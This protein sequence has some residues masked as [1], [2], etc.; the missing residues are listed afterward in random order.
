M[1]QILRKI[2]MGSMGV[3]VICVTACTNIEDKYVKNKYMVLSTTQSVTSASV[4]KSLT[5]NNQ[6]YNLKYQTQYFSEYYLEDEEGYDWTKL[7]TIHYYPITSSLSKIKMGLDE[8]MKKQ[9]LPFHDSQLKYDELTWQMVYPPEI[10]SKKFNNIETDTG[11]G[12]E[13]ECGI[14]SVLYGEQHMPADDVKQQIKGYIRN[15][16]ANK[17]Q[18]SKNAKDIIEKNICKLK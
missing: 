13:T 7:I 3:S 6:E 14:V 4:P 12:M 2:L 9:D 8:R 5:Y 16:K 15:L 11:F 17:N 18:Y 10:G 1:Y